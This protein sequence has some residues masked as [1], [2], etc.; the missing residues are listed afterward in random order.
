MSTIKDE[1]MGV[2]RCV[3]HVLVDG[4]FQKVSEWQ[5]ADD[6]ECSSGKNVEQ[7]LTGIKRNLQT[8]ISSVQ[9]SISNID[10]KVDTKITST[11]ITNIEAV[12]SLPSNASSNPTTL[13]LIY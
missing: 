8:S 10:S 5:S 12:R 7:E 11:T 4:L 3:K 1:N 13:Y 6:V 9:T 2:F